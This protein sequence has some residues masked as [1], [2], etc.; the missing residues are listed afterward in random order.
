MTNPIRLIALADLTL[1]PLNTRQM[2]SRDELEA[3]AESIA[4]TGLLQNL[5]GLERDGRVEIVGGGKRLRALQKLAEEGWSR[6]IG[7]KRIDPVPVLVTV[8]DWQAIAWSGAENTARTALSPADEIAA[9]SALRDK[10]SS[11]AMIARTYAVSAAHVQRMLKLADLPEPVLVNLRAGK[12]S[13][14][15]ARAFTIAP[16]PRAAIDV[17]EQALQ[18]GWR[19]WQIRSALKPSDITASDRRARY[20]GI[21]AYVAAGGSIT[22]DLFED[23]VYLHDDKLLDHLARE[24]ADRE[25]EVLRTEGGWAWGKCVDHG[26][27]KTDHDWAANLRPLFRKEGTL[28]EG[29]IEEYDRLAD[30]VQSD[31]LDDEG[32]ARLQELQDRLDGDWTDED[33]AIG[34][35]VTIVN[36]RGE[37]QVSGAYARPEDDARSTGTDDD[38]GGGDAADGAPA[39]PQA[40]AIPQNLRDDLRAIR[41]RALQTALFDR[42]ETLLDLLAFSLLGETKPWERPLAIQAE[43]THAT[44]AKAEG[45]TEDT[46]FDKPDRAWSDNTAAAFAAFVKAGKSARNRVLDIA[47]T[48]AFRL[49]EGPL[50][51]ALTADLPVNPR[52]IWTPTKEDYFGRVKV[53]HLDAI[54]YE[55]TPVPDTD[56]VRG[57][58]AGLKKA[59]K[60]QR[61]HRLFNDLDFREAMGL[62][63]AECQAIDSW[64]PPELV[65]TAPKAQDEAPSDESAAA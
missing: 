26:G 34:G 31:G 3:M 40:E 2:V 42:H 55:L 51:E 17:L 13:I 9:Y 21:E 36:Y 30:L 63:R 39:T 8:D 18:N 38:A 23:R 1:S 41:L 32:E 33:R 59:E 29:D 15:Q 35:L 12:L 47:L 53:E 11:S 50:V 44:P 25:T 49:H 62:S 22:E 6:K 37:L 48:R 45:L 16:S 64:L 7:Q 43:P 52:A 5:I 58:W 61:L 10:G 60:A 19:E 56:P 24:K 57:E 46:R 14:D 65:F 28:P 54:W 20:V 4:T 27:D